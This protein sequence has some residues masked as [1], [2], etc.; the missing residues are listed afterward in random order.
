MSSKFISGWLLSHQKTYNNLCLIERFQ[1]D[2]NIDIFADQH[3]ATL[4]RCVPVEAP[5]FAV[6]LCF[7]AQTRNLHTPGIFP[8]TV[9]FCIESHRLRYAAHRQIAEYLVLIATRVLDLRALKGEHR[10]ML[11]IEEIGRAQ[12]PIALFIACIDAGSINLC[13]HPR[14]L[15]M[16]FIDMQMPTQHIKMPTHSG[17]HHVFYRKCS[18]RMRWINFPC[19]NERS[20]LYSD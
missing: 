7:G 4:K 18:F 19:H 14:I 12:V 1:V 11:R 9:V 8:L 6:Q 15:R 17:E 2:L 10:V 20:S 16:L 13:I 5:F 3:A